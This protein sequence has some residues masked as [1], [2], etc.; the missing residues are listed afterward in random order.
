MRYLADVGRQ[1]FTKGANIASKARWIFVHKDHDGSEP[2][3]DVL[4]HGTCML[5]KAAG[6]QYGS[7][8]NIKPV[9]VR[10]ATRTGPN[11]VRQGAEDYLEGVA[12]VLDDVGNGKKAILS[13]SWYYP[14]RKDDGSWMFPDPQNSLQDESDGFRIRLRMML[15]ELVRKGVYPITGSGNDGRVSARR[16]IS[17]HADT[18]RIPLMAGLRTLGRPTITSTI[19]LGLS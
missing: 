18:C 1:E 13:M 9:I 4:Q 8:K 17:V 6:Y 19:S 3:N 7:A 14:R 11:S 2:K 10:A 5:S 16:S 12:K 15:S